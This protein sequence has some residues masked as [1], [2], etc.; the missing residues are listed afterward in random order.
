LSD[1]DAGNLWI[2]TLAF[3]HWI[4]ER[5]P[6]YLSTLQSLDVPPPIILM[7]TLQGVRGAR[8][9]V[10]PIPLEDLP[11]LDRDVL[12]LPEIVINSTAPMPI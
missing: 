5:L 4:L 2:P 8:L 1:L 10:R 11:V 6:N 9:G 12:E 3:D 7:T